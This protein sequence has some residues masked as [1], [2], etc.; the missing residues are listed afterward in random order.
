MTSPVIDL[1]R[2]EAEWERSGERPDGDEILAV[3]AEVRRLREAGLAVVN[4]APPGS[5]V[6]DHDMSIPMPSEA[7]SGC[8]ARVALLKLDEVL[9]GR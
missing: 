5:I 9:R 6:H 1:D 2:L 3:F 8:R 4:E 7:C